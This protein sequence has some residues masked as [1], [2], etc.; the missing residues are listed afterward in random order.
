MIG[1]V[2]NFFLVLAGIAI[3][4]VAVAWVRWMRRPRAESPPARNAGTPQSVAP[5]P[6]QPKRKPKVRDAEPPA[7]PA[8]RPVQPPKPMKAVRR[9]DQPDGKRRKGKAQE[10]PAASP[11]AWSGSP[12]GS[13]STYESPSSSS[14]TDASPV[15]SDSSTS[16]Y[17]WSSSDTSSSSDSSSSYDASTSDSSSS[18]DFGGGGSSDSW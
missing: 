10:R 8:P 6:N 11:D 15:S 1:S 17:D 13:W 14:P 12:D 5:P 4:L 16:S 7:A 2:I 9:R 18:G 3:V